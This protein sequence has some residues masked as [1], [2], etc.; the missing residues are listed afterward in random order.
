MKGKG[1]AN[2]KADPRLVGDQNMNASLPQCCKS[3][4]F[5]LLAKQGQAINSPNAL[6]MGAIA[7]SMHHL[8][9]VSPAAVDAKLKG[10]ANTVRSRG[11]GSQAVVALL[12]E[13]LFEEEGFA[14]NVD[15]YY[16]PANSYLPAVLQTKRG[17]PI[18]L[19]LLYKCVADRL[20]LQ[21]WGVGLPGHFLVAVE[22]EDNDPMLIDP[23]AGGRLL[24]VEEA[25]TRMQ[26]LLGPEAEWSAV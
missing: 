14:G 9:D 3:S 12:H 10:Y 24:T 22:L 13:L 4:A 1:K 11:Q 15:D 25:H 16:N 8:D 21:P 26:D 2:T 18:T 20:G 5:K 23:F 19:S 17:L 6:L 7:I